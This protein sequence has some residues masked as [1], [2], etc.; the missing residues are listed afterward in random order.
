LFGGFWPP[1]AHTQARADPQS[2]QNLFSSSTLDP[3]CEQ[4]IRFLSREA[5]KTL[6]DD[7][8]SESK[9]MP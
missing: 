7:R 4:I 2:P 5:D 9:T 8:G 3:Q 1:Q 6:E